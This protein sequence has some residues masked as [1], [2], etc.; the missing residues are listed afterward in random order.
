MKAQLYPVENQDPLSSA[1]SILQDLWQAATLDGLYLPTYQEEAA[2]PEGQFIQDPAQ[3]EYADPFAPVMPVNHAPA[4]LKALREH[5]DWRLGVFLRPCEWRSFHILTKR[6]QEKTNHLFAISA[7]CTGAMRPED[8]ILLSAG[9]SPGLTRQ[10]LHFAAQGGLLPSRHRFSCQICE[11]P[12]P[13]E[14]DL[15]FELFGTPTDDQLILRYKDEQ[16]AQMVSERRSGSEVPSD[17][18]EHRT[19]V[20][21]DLA[22]WRSRSF[23]KRKAQLKPEAL[24]VDGLVTHLRVC[25]KCQLALQQHCP[26]VVLDSIVGEDELSL[27]QLQAWLRS[28][29]GC[30]VC[31]QDCPQ[32]YPLFTVIFALRNLN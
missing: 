6:S 30:G 19:Q 23:E 18:G 26:T 25:Q 11:E 1:R 21:G 27:N 7:D 9:D 20:L 5:P 31:D 4:A 29:S 12:F 15:H 14:V 3:L 2:I 28:C 17:A 24:T 16:I 8:Y 32:D 22:R 13:E 10:V